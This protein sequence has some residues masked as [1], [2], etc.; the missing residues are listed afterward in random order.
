MTTSENRTGRLYGSVLAFAATAFLAS[1]STLAHAD[2]IPD[3]TNHA[4]QNCFGT[5]SVHYYEE[6]KDKTVDGRIEYVV[7]GP[8]GFDASFPG[9]YP[10]GDNKYV[11][12]YQLYNNA[13]DNN[14]Y[15][16]TFTVAL[17]G[18]T[19]AANCWWVDPSPLY[20]SGITPSTSQTIPPSMPTSA[21]WRY[22]ATN[23]IDPGEN[24]QLLVFTS[25]NPPTFHLATIAS[26]SSWA[27]GGE[28]DTQY[29]SWEGQLP[30][31]LPEPSSI[32]SLLAIGGAILVNRLCKRK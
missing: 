28:G 27:H 32:F 20:P 18:D 13:G 16:K 17:V 21:L 9:K 29:N 19:G 12:R 1:F 2:L 10:S 7:Y 15:M 31:P 25:P 23:P 6:D 14:D 4:Y 30:S 24:S 8:G 26:T 11:Y 3:D 5:V 22:T